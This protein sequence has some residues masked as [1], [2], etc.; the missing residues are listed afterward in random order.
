MW[1]AFCQDFYRWYN[2]EYRHAGIAMLTP[3]MLHGGMANNVLA[4]R[5]RVMAAAHAAN[6][7]RFNGHV[8]KPQQVP[9][10]GWINKPSDREE[11]RAM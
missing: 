2:V 8:P 11:N 5:H 3:S 10:E 6:P 7:R 9:T 4:A 1:I